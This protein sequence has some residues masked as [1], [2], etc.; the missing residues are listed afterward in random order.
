MKLKPSP[1]RI[2][3]NPTSP[4]SPSPRVKFTPSWRKTAT[5]VSSNQQST[6]NSSHNIWVK[7]PMATLKTAAAECVPDKHGIY[8]TAFT[9]SEWSGPVSWGSGG[10]N[11]LKARLEGLGH[12]RNPFHVYSIG[13]HGK[14]KFVALD[15]NCESRITFA[16]L[17]VKLFVFCVCLSIFVFP[18]SIYWKVILKKSIIYIWWTNVGYLLNFEWKTLE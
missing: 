11:R 16:H 6:R 10:L 2:W 1:W 14:I 18:M 12:Q 5:L 15:N 3:S 9:V 8:V 7:L 17:Y 4:A 13:V